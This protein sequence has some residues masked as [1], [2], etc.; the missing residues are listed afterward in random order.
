MLKLFDKVLFYI[1]VPKCVG[2][3]ERLEYGQLA[4]CSKCLL[5]YQRIKERNC[6]CCSKNLCECGCANIFMESHYT[7]SVSKV[8]RYFSHDNDRVE[9]RLIYS[10]KEDNR[11]DVVEFLVSEMSRS[12]SHVVEKPSECVFV[13]VPR[14][15]SAVKEFGIDHA[16]SLAKSLARKF[17]ASYENILVSRSKQAQKTKHGLIERYQNVNFN[18]R[19][20]VDLHNRR[21]IIVDDIIT[22]GASVGQAAMLLH[23]L[24]AKKIYAASVAIAYKDE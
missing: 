11:S 19:R 9:N 10:L 16:A 5:E 13:N 14:R 21:V 18:Y 20:K 1:S 15:K 12:I 8:F 23:G 24:G 3:G 2:C 7:R 17:G 22:T 4:L 6:S